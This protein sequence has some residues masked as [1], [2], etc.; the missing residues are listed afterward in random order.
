MKEDM[1][2]I[3]LGNGDLEQVLPTAGVHY[4]RVDPNISRNVWI[5]S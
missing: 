4:L 2:R 3:E 1:A 5:Y